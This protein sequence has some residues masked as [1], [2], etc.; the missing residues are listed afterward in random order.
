MAWKLAILL[1][2]IIA[3]LTMPSRAI[4]DGNKSGT[5]K[6]EVVKS[7]RGWRLM[8]NGTPYF[9][10]GAGGDA[11]KQLLR[12]VGGNSFRTW[13]AVN[14]GDQLD[15]AQRLGLTVT[16]GMW[17]GHESRGFDYNN[18]EQVARQFDRCRKFVLQYK[19]HPALLMW[20]IGNE[21]EGEKAGDNPAIWRAVN[22][23][24]AMVKQ[25]DSNHPTMTVMVEVGG[26][27]VK[28][29]HKFC[30]S[31]DVVGINSYGGAPSV[32]WRYRK[33]G[34]TKPYVITEFGPPG[35]WE[36]NEKAFGVPVEKSSTKKAASYLEAWRKGIEAERD[37]LCLGGYAFAWGSKQEAT[38]TW[39]GLVL[40]DGRRTE[41][42]DALSEAW[43]NKPVKS[44]CP[45][46]ESLLITAPEKSVVEPGGEATAALVTTNPGGDELK[47]RWELHRDSGNV[48]T[49]GET[50]AETPQ[51]PDAI[52][53]SDT[54]SCTLKMPK[55][56]GIYRLYAYVLDTHGGAAVAN[57][58]LKV[59]GPA[60]DEPAPKAELPF[61]VLGGQGKKPRFAATGY[62]GNIR[63]IHLDHESNETPRVA[64]AVSLRCE[65]QA[66][67]GWAGVSW[68]D[69][70]NDWGDRPGGVDMSGAKKLTFWARGKQ[71][72]EKIRFA[73]G[74]ISGKKMYRDTAKGE[75]AVDL[76]PEWRQY[77]L[78]LAGLDLSRV[79]T[80]FAWFTMKV[81]APIVFYLDEIKYE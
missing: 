25:A 20:A 62:M 4:A 38:A 16:V 24:A 77:S 6:V 12:D 3:A 52:I 39:Y 40:S 80:P 69:P 59:N 13:D 19:D 53:K 36:V 49:G 76:T 2:L 30:P 81:N 46:I 29:V 27:R 75:L 41:A 64:G 61:V 34:G 37:K 68:Q 5:S 55:S 14:I 74:G 23:I 8:R 1:S 66:M 54:K 70:A 7:E 58:L 11:S 67:D 18:P 26:E 60:I 9:I 56:G 73:F 45:R 48:A 31:I 71:G 28:C 33:A 35:V 50:Q 47:V 21:M 65:Y 43:T 57:V 17:L 32:P 15:E 63:A 72:G 78:D 42:V 51:Y 44:P 10:Q 79:K 22:D